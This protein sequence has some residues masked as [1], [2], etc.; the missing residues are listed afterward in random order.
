MLGVIAFHAKKDLLPGGYLGVDVFFV[1]SG[2]LITSIILRESA[3][4]TFSVRRFWERRIRRILPAA[5]FIL[6]AVS[7]V[8]T[9]LIY[10]PDLL[11]LSN[12]KLAALLSLANIYFWKNTFDYWGNA[13]DESPFL[14]YWSL[15]VEEQYYLLYPILILVLIA[16]GRKYLLTVLV[17]LIIVSFALFAYGAVYDPHAT[18]YLLP[19]RIWQL[20]AGCLLAILSNH[21]P[22]ANKSLGTIIGVLLIG[23]TYL[24]PLNASGIGYESFIAVVGACLIIWSGSNK[25]STLILENNFA[26]F[27]GQISYSLYLWHWPIIVTIKK[28][29]NYNNI[30]SSITL[31]IIGGVALLALSLF[32]YYCIETYFRK[33]KHGT[34]IALSFA[35][36]V[37]LYFFMIEPNLLKRPYSSHYEMPSWHGRYYDLK[38]GGELTRSFQIIANSV[39]T[40]KREASVTAYKTGGIIRQ[41]SSTDIRVV[42]IGDSHAIMWSKVVDDVTE[43]LDLTTSLWS[44]NG[45][46]GLIKIPA[47]EEAG[48]YLNGKERFE[49]DSARQYFIKKWNPDIVIVATLWKNVDENSANNFFNFLELHA[50]NVILVESPPALNGVGNRNTYQYLSFLGMD[51][52][53]SAN[54][55]QLWE[56]ISL[57]NTLNTRE[58][59]LKIVSNRANFFF[60]PTA[61]LFL[62]D[63]FAIVASGKHI[64]YLDDDHLTDEGTKLTTSRFKSAIQNILNGE[65]KRI[66]IQ[67]TQYVK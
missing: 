40:P 49:Y 38:P 29:Q 11:Q 34:S 59:L 30:P 53:I 27:I 58:K 52:S 3:E 25:A 39:H 6:L 19:T 47:V 17:V 31:F 33:H 43:E 12:Q 18:F 35:T 2:F 7:L 37:G 44:M 62:S 56:H 46:H 1:I 28:I 51:A 14:H 5:T 15:S 36:L 67:R 32:S 66:P 13:S 22:L 26:I 61:D 63:S 65:R 48:H 54:N 23:G 50:K 45:E 60:L 55:N 9:F 57:E 24:F 16:K 64:F 8:Q 42:L 41:R 10:K 4:G 21:M 20:G